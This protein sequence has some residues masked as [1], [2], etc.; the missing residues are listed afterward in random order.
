NDSMRDGFDGL[1]SKLDSQTGLLSQI[2]NN[3]AETVSGLNTINETLT[4]EIDTDEILGDYPIPDVSETPVDW[5]EI[6]NMPGDLP[7]TGTPIVWTVPIPMGSLGGTD[8]EL[9]VDIAN[10]IPPTERNL[11]RSIFVFFAYLVFIKKVFER[12]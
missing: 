8:A 2:A 9:V 1:G 5:F 12:I 6:L 7:T 4:A 3:T 10:A 11:I